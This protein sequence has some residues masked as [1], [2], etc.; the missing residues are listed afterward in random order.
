MKTRSKENILKKKDGTLVCAYCLSPIV[1]EHEKEFEGN[2]LYDEYDSYECTCEEWSNDIQ[3]NQEKDEL[4]EEYSK[5][6]NKDIKDITLK[7]E[8]EF[9]AK[10]KVLKKFYKIV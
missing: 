7:N 6:L 1:V 2:R 10:L 9:R 3:Y 8:L 4:E 5:K